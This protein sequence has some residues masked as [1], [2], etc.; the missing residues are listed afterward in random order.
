MED[1]LTVFLK[2]KGE[3]IETVNTRLLVDATGYARAVMYKH[4]REKPNFLKAVGIEY[5]IAVPEVD[6][7]KYQ[8]NLVFFFSVINGVPKVMAGFSYG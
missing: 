1:K 5:L 3:E 4:R 7:Q 8:D 6:Y 2:S